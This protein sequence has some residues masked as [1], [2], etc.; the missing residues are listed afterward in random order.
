MTDHWVFGYGSLMWQP[1]FDYE[2]AVPGFLVGLR[3]SL[4]I[5]SIVHRGSPKYPG[6]V[7][8]LDIGGFCHGI[9]F[10]INHAHKRKV[11]AYLRARELNTNVYYEQQK[12]IALH[13][14][15]ERTVRAT[16]FVVNRNHRQYAGRL[17]LSRQAYIVRRSKGRS[18]YNID[19]FRNTLEHLRSL[20]IYDVDLERL[21]LI[22]RG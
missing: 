21:S 10:R 19:Y 13:D 3:R 15:S 4:C 17:P 8:G 1:G 5:H 20:E 2:E 18:G 11:R 16:C 6:L 7:L 9:A 12:P 22:M 14:G